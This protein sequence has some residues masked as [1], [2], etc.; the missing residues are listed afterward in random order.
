MTDV[1]NHR[2]Q[3]PR[4]DMPNSRYASMPVQHVCSLPASHEEDHYCPCNATTPTD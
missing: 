3:A 4:G 2:W 1:C